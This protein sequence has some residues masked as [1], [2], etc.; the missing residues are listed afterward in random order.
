MNSNAGIAQKEDRASRFEAVEHNGGERGLQDHR[1]RP[2]QEDRRIVRNSNDQRW[3]QLHQSPRNKEPTAIRTESNTFAIQADI[4][5][6][7]IIYLILISDC[8]YDQRNRYNFYYDQKRLFRRPVS[9]HSK[10]FI[11]RTLE[12]DQFS[13][14]GWQDLLK[15]QLFADLQP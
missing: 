9:E 10:D 14:M 4:Y 8:D 6:I 2:R 7:G 3:H 15:H 12:V 13:R 5:S 11:R 1:P